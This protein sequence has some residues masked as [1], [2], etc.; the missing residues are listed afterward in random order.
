MPKIK[1]RVSFREIENIPFK[2]VD[3]ARRS[4]PYLRRTE[5]QNIREQ[6]LPGTKTQFVKVTVP[7]AATSVSLAQDEGVIITINLTVNNATSIIAWPQ[8]SI[9]IDDILGDPAN[10]WFG[11]SSLSSGDKNLQLGFA[12]QINT[13]TRSG[14]LSNQ[15]RT[16]GIITNRDTSAHVYT[17]FAR[18][19]YI[20]I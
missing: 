16:V 11:G 5:Q 7:G 10:L 14:L 18:W 3:S 8:M 1:K 13:T 12:Q 15:S 9:Y 2:E 6:E 17:L 20:I 4:I 19:F